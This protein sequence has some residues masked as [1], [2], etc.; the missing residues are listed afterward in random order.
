MQQLIIII[1][2]NLHQ[3]EEVCFHVVETMTER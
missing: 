2:T 3:S 1:L